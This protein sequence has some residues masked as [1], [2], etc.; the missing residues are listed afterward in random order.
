MRNLIIIGASG[1]LGSEL[2]KLFPDAIYTYNNTEIKH[3]NA[4]RLD[5]TDQE[6]LISLLKRFEIRDIIVTSALTDVDKCEIYPDLAYKINAD[7]FKYITKY[8]KQVNGRL[9][10]ISTDYV[11]SGEQGNYSEEDFREPINVYGKSKKEA[12]D[13]ILDSGIEYAIIRTSG[14]F[15][16][17]KATGKTNFFLWIY[18]NLKENKEIY[19]VSDQ[20]YSPTLNSILARA[21]REIYD[22]EISGLIHFSSLDKISRLGFG[23]IVAD[24]FGF[25]KN[26]IRETEMKDMKWKA[27]RPKD[28]SLNNEKAIKL[29]DEKPFTVFDEIK[30]IKLKSGFNEI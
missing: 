26:L 27:K 14:I 23:Y 28:S 20:Y 25:D 7:P 24:I 9:I 22:R 16:I 13:I 4:Y 18:N 10:Q 12:E 19:L 29:L 21:I 2:I 3:K 11:F 6:S 30:S 15:G 5:I 8:L 1:L 17:N